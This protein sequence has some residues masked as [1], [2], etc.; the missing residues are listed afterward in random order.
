MPPKTNR[1]SKRRRLDNLTP[2]E[3]NTSTKD[4]EAMTEALSDAVTAKVLQ[5]L[6]DNGMFAANTQVA[7]T[8]SSSHTLL[9]T[10]GPIFNT[11]DITSGIQIPNNNS[12]DIIRIPAQE[13]A[14]GTMINNSNYGTA[15]YTPVGRPLYT[16]INV[17]LQ[18]KILNR[19]FVEMSDILV[20]HRPSE[21]GFHFEVHNQKVGLASG[22]KRKFVNIENWTDA[23]AIFASVLRRGSPNHPT[24]A[25]DLAIYADLIRQIYKDGGDWYF[26]DINFRQNM[27]NDGALSW[28]C[29]D[30]LLHT[31]ALSRNQ[32]K[33]VNSNFNLGNVSKKS[34][35][36]GNFIR[37]P[38]SAKP[39]P[40]NAPRKTCH[41]YNEG[42]SCDGNCGY[43]HLCYICYRAHPMSLC[44]KQNQTRPENRQTSNITKSPESQDPPNRSTVSNK[45]KP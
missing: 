11:D 25:E 15:S 32:N 44:I 7:A 43:L 17:K 1:P 42:R 3:M 18:E 23:F 37:F 13:F 22:K 27:Q 31:R 9:Q 5:N 34:A 45:S 33:N 6:K 21:L 20:N 12:D 41:R 38:Q 19:E 2:D 28:N 29:V 24:L 30:Q 8:C 40:A 14:T 39:F 10:P 16:K 36:I 4:M 35:K 26:Y